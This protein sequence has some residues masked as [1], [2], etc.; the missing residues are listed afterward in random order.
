MN[1]VIAGPGAIGCLFASLLRAT[2]RTITLLDKDP[3]RARILERNGIRVETSGDSRQTPIRATVDP[4]CI[5]G[6]DLVLICVK[7]HATSSLLERI[8]PRIP[9]AIPVVSLQNG[10]DPIET[11]AQ[12]VGTTRSVCAVTAHGATLLNT[13]HLVHAGTGIT[14]VAPFS[15]E[16]PSAARV[17]THLLKRSGLETVFVADRQRVLWSKLVINAGINPVTALAGVCNGVLLERQDLFQ[18]ARQAAQ[19]GQQVAAAMGITLDF[20]NTE[21]ELRQICTL[22]S[23]NISSMLQDLQRG[24]ATEVDAI[25][26]AIVRAGQRLRVPVPVNRELLAGIRRAEQEARG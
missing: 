24:K 20:A 15:P 23:G 12:F 21:R 3:D 26:G 11:L 10:I 19:E 16:F 13:G 17:L 14:R 1:I 7:A 9:P 6:A 4:R 22:T 5:S 18:R 25:N 8:A 2:G